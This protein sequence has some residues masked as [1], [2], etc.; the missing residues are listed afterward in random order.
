MRVVGSQ[1]MLAPFL[2]AFFA[3]FSAAFFAAF[4]AIRNSPGEWRVAQSNARVRSLSAR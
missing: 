4:Y 3:R 1:R 2:N